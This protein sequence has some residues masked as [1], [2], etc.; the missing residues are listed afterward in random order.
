MEKV[1]ILNTVVDNLTMEE[2]VGRIEQL[3]QE[4]ADAYVVTPNLD[5]LLCLDEDGEF[6]EAYEK[7]DL[8]LADGISLVLLAKYLRVPLKEK[9]SGSD[10]FPRVCRM[11]AKHGWSLFILGAAP[12]VAEEAG[13]R[14]AEKNPGLVIAGTYSPPLGFENDPEEIERIIGKVTSAGPDLMAIA[15]SS[16]KGEKFI[17]RYRDRLGVPL[18]MSVGAAVDFEAGNKKRAPGWVSDMGFEWLYRTFQEPKR[19]GKRVL[20]D[21][22]GLIPLIKKY[23]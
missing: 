14:L 12:G 18:T 15:I 17:C 11:A 2:A 23:R 13:R 7:A 10:L 16:M 8:V 19:I 9:V 5:H 21:I 6:R 1:R 22:A 20:R 4:R 3:V